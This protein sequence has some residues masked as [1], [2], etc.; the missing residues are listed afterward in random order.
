MFENSKDVAFRNVTSY[1]VWLIRYN[2]M[3][4]PVFQSLVSYT[5]VAFTQQILIRDKINLSLF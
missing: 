1:V 4:E 3:K 2:V 5:L